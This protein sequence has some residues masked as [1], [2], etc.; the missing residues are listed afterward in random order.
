MKEDLCDVVNIAELWKL[1][2]LYEAE[3]TAYFHVVAWKHFLEQE[4]RGCRCCSPLYVSVIVV[5]T[6]THKHTAGF[7]RG[8]P[9]AL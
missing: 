4:E 3:C 6:E 9:G 1:C 7:S 2:V 5:R 8:E